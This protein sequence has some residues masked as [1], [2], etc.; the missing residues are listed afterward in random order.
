MKLL[1]NTPYLILMLLISHTG[2][3]AQTPSPILIDETHT[4]ATFRTCTN[5]AGTISLGQIDAMSN[6]IDLDTMFLCFGD[7]VFIDHNGDFSLTGDPDSTTE[8]GIGYAWYSCPP[9]AE[10]PT[11]Q[12]IV[13]DPC[14]LLDPPPIN[15][16]W[17][18]VDNPNGDAWFEN[19]FNINDTTTLQDFFNS[20]DPV[21]LFF[22]PITFD[23]L[24]AG[25]AVYEGSP[26]GECVNVSVD[27]AFSIV[28]LNPISIS[29][30]THDGGN[31][32]I[33]GSFTVDGGLPEFDGSEYNISIQLKGTT[34]TATV[35]SGPASSG[36]VVEFIAEEPGTYIFTISDGK[37]CTYFAEFCIGECV[38]L[39][40]ESAD[41]DEGEEFCLEVSIVNFQGM[42]ALTGAIT[43]NPNVIELISATNLALPQQLIL[44]TAFSQNGWL[45]LL[46]F[47]EDNG[48]TGGQSLPDSTAIIELCFRAV[49]NPGQSSPVTLTERLTTDLIALKANDVPVGVGTT[50]GVVNILYPEELGLVA[51]SC[52]TLAGT[53]E[54][55]ITVTAYGGEPPYEI[56]FE[57]SDDPGINGTADIDEIGGMA[58]FENLPPTSGPGVFYNVGVVDA[59]GDTVT[60]EVIIDPDGPPM[61]DLSGTE[62]TCQNAINGSILAEID[63]QGPFVIEWSNGSFT[64]TILNNIGIGNYTISVTDDFGCQTSASIELGF[65][66]IVINANITNASC[67]G[68]PNGSITVNASGGEPINM[69]EYRY[70]WQG[71]SPQTATVS[72]LSDLNPGTYRLTVTDNNGCSVVDSFEVGFGTGIEISDL[73]IVDES[74]TGAMDGSISIT[75]QLS[76]GAGSTFFFWT[77]RDDNNNILPSVGIGCC[78]SVLEDLGQGNYTVTVA[79]TSGCEANFEYVVGA[80]EPIVIDLIEIQDEFCDTPQSGSIQIEVSGGEVN[81]SSDYTII[82]DHGDNGTFIE[83]LASGEYTVRVSDLTDCEEVATFNVENADA[84]VIDS[85]AVVPA[86]C[87]GNGQGELTVFFTPGSGNVISIDWEDQDQNSYGGSTITG[88]NAGTYTVYILSADGCVAMETVELE[89]EGEL[90][91]DE[92]VFNSP[93]CPGDS[94]GR[95]S[96][97]LEGNPGSLDYE[98]SNGSTNQGVLTDIPAGTYSVTVSQAGGECDPLEI[99]GILLED[100]DPLSAEFINV[101]GTNCFDSCEG[102]A[103]ISVSGGTGGVYTYLWENGL[104]GPFN[105]TLCGGDNSV[106]VSDGLCTDT[107]FVDIPTP[108]Q[109][110]IDLIEVRNPSCHGISDGEIQIEATGGTGPNYAFTW[111][112]P[113]GTMGAVLSNVSGGTYSVEVIDMN[114]CRDTFSVVLEE[115]DSLVLQV[116]AASTRPI[117]CSNRA[118]GQIGLSVSGGNGNNQFNWQP[119]VSNSLVAENL[120]AGLYEIEVVDQNGCT[121][122]TSYLMEEASSISFSFD[123]PGQVNCFGDTFEFTVENASG[124]SG[125]PYQYAINF[126]GLIPLGETIDL[127]AGNYV[128]SVFDDAGCSAI[129]SFA[130]DQPQ[131]IIVNLPPQI[132]IQLGESIQ[133]N[134]EIIDPVP[135]S[136]YQWLTENDILDCYDCRD[137]LATPVIEEE[138]T[139]VIENQNGC[140]AS[141]STT[142]ILESIRNVYIPTAFSPNNDGVNDLFRVF[143]GIGVREV[144]TFRVFDRW[145]KKV[146]ERINIPLSQLDDIGWDGLVNGELANP[147]VFIYMVEVEFTDG[148][149]EV[150]T[151]EVMLIR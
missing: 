129:D 86:S 10:G 72:T 48:D 69:N 63:G 87:S 116:N 36:E 54:G 16:L 136:T 73:N 122:T 31:S 101:V 35:I 43:W 34:Q 127:F 12:D 124:G 46:W 132:E 118:D 7:R 68:V 67:E 85:I 49:G 28:Y 29:N 14:V 30:L 96:V 77:W 88:L 95:I 56:F 84:P 51:T 50:N 107:F 105:P 106:I 139:L 125:G 108:E 100:P 71:R 128:V 93:S 109:V 13:A 11:L 4:G 5:E 112:D 143:T 1:R 52:G 41:V 138:I 126:G 114:N 92:I 134:P 130:V 55:A 150:Y 21:Q 111:D 137:P 39:I 83:N 65:T 2:L 97:I 26:A 94:D 18:Y 64:D 148:F 32:D 119:D 151:G 91:L 123:Q 66:P 37:S 17:V 89:I 60:I 81:D 110:G 140:Q 144:P 8:G 47:D 133:L 145:G 3:I 6:D 98:W 147:G 25:S 146:F 58:T 79:D 75:A 38:E 45:T 115:P 76:G 141:A 149:V 117:S 33:E 20:G 103:E 23:N 135:V 113:D 15:D 90:V 61:V 102:R 53:S 70:R 44:N 24:M 9:T 62:P 57:K 27:Q 40:V 131:E 42:L 19:G 74:C 80:P 121:D 78:Q 142:F 82:W 22:A 99:E 59:L 120:S 104:V